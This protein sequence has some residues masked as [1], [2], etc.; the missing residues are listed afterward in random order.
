MVVSKLGTACGY[1]GE[2]GKCV[3]EAL[4]SEVP[5]YL[6]SSTAS[7]SPLVTFLSHSAARHFYDHIN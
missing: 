1:V 2:S 5:M 6:P 3:R 4:A 7:H